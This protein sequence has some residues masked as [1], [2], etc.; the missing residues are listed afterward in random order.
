MK[1][2]Y[3]MIKI[4]RESR[5][6][7]QDELAKRLGISQVAV[8]KIET[9]LSQINDDLIDKLAIHLN[10]PISFFQNET[11]IINSGI[12]LHRKRLALNKK[13]EGYIDALMSIF[14]MSISKF[15]EYVDLEV[16]LPEI[17]IDEYLSAYD[18]ADKL[19]E[20][21]KIPCGSINN[22]IY[23]LEGNGIFVFEV[24]CDFSTF[25]AV[26][27]Y[28][29]SL[30]VGI[31]IINKNQSPDRYRFT[32]AHELGHIIMHRS[33]ISPNIEKE[34]NNFAS[35]FLMPRNDIYEDLVDLKFWDLP[36]YKQ[37]WKVSMAAL[38]Y[39]AFDLKAIDSKKYASLNVRLSQ[40]GY[41]KNEPICGIDKERPS[42][43]K[44]LLSYFVTNLQYSEK[45]ILSVLNLF[46]DDYIKYFDLPYSNNFSPK[47]VNID[48]YRK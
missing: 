36:Q 25:D 9:G 28:N 34:A 42:L 32:L 15:L 10:Y 1:Y 35:A 7:T 40:E 29:N 31:I 17:L 30:G 24:D 41:K 11:K 37:I 43:F 47:V 3:S 33:S 38:I 27:A 26:S 23:Y 6:L 21:W 2:N 14:T 8:H 22:L 20:I 13:D 16:N 39:R 19:R 44:D 5:K 45:D 12:R 48:N 18:I 46:R 4:A